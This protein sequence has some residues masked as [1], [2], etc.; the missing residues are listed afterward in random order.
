MEGGINYQKAVEKLWDKIPINDKILLFR[1]DF[2]WIDAEE[3]KKLETVS[4]INRIKN[5]I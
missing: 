3:K 5:L 2:G 1:S 4:R